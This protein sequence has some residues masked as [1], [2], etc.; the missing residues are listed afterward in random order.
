MTDFLQLGSLRSM[1][2]TKTDAGYSV[3]AVGTVAAQVCPHCRSSLL[4]GH[5]SI[6]Q[7]FRD[8][9]SHGLSV[10]LHLERRRFRCRGCNRT[11]FEH[12]ADLDDQRLATR[13]LVEYVQIQSLQRPFV[14][15]AEVVGLDEKT[16]RNIFHDY[17]EHLDRTIRYETPAQLGIDEVK[18]L[19]DYRC[20]LTNVDRRTVFDLLPSR[21][22]AD[23]MPYFRDLRDKG[24]VE[25]VAMDMWTPYRQVI[26]GQLP[27][28]RIVVDRFHIQ[29]TAVNAMEA[30][31]KQ[32]RRSLSPHQRL[33]MKNDR[34]V[35][36]ARPYK[37]RG[38]D[39]ETLMK[40]CQ[41]F[42][43]LAVAYELKEAF[44]SI[45]D[46]TK[47]A[48]AENAFDHWA[49]CVPSNFA[50]TFG[51]IVKTVADWREPVFAYWESPR[52]SNGYTE[53]RNGFV[54]EINQS[55][56]GYS[57]TA[58][59]ARLLFNPRARAAST[60]IIRDP[61]AGDAPTFGKS[62]SFEFF[63]NRP[64]NRVH[65]KERVVEYG[66][67]MEVLAKMLADGEFDD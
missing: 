16:V 34:H 33:K 40:I 61:I 36:L 2:V 25:W 30:I 41:E 46:E 4:Y 22:K 37:L 39:S 47:R 64:R 24:K 12:I 55:G 23:L 38:N 17:V 6:R 13:R 67:S 1:A 44:L 49:Q 66:P 53:N 8:V 35:L 28:A 62:T 31:R 27:Q 65:Y 42:P 50:A 15:V 59:R 32:I 21:T 57:F 10:V 29:R 5:G 45:W 7:T 60:Q 43:E 51:K 14:Q 20:M 52:V 48:D 3:D 26:A 54:Q 9:P 11:L 63:V 19:G 58:L 18:L 56:R